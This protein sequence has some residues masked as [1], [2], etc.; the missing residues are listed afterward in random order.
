M[1]VVKWILLSCLCWNH[2]ECCF[3]SVSPCSKSFVRNA[4]TPLPNFAVFCSHLS[5]E[6]LRLWLSHPAGMEGTAR[7]HWPPA[8]LQHSLLC[9]SSNDTVLC[10]AVPVLTSSGAEDRWPQVPGGTGAVGMCRCCPGF[11]E[12]YIVFRLEMTFKI[13]RSHD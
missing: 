12:S 8:V 5:A 9:S 6:L 10:T 3:T 4:H 13:I 2:S 1:A 11:V 7:C